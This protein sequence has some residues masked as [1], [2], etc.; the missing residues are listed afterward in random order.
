MSRVEGLIKQTKAFEKDLGTFHR[1]AVPHANRNALNQTAFAARKMWITNV[2]KEFTN[3]NTFTTRQI[4]VVKA[5]GTNL[6]KMKAVIGSLAPYMGKREKGETK[7]AKGR[8]VAIPTAAA[9]G[10]SG[11]KRTRLIRKAFR[12]RSIRLPSRG[13]GSEAQRNAVSI[14]K[15]VAS[16]KRVAYLERGNQ[17]GLVRIGGR[18]RK[19]TFRTIYNLS[20]RTVRVK[21]EPTL[22]PTMASARQ[23][24][25]LVYR[26]ALKA[27]IVRQRLFRDAKN[28]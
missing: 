13:K 15:A 6:H 7:R 26:E 2:R 8:G 10:Q 27:E 28:A 5:S 18:A 24:A 21:P 23:F 19:R 17:R 1:N 12:L 16:G 9:A 11:R 3:R 4:R 22:A 14:R 25:P 20:R